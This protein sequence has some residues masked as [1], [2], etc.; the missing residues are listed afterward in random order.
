MGLARS[1]RPAARSLFLTAALA[2]VLG[3]APQPGATPGFDPCELDTSARPQDDLF[4]Y[5]NGGWLD[6]TPLPD[7]R[8]AY[9][10]FLE[11]GDAFEAR[12]R[13]II[14]DAARAPR[15]SRTSQQ[16]VDLYASMLN[17]SRVEELGTKPIKA[18]ID[19][20]A[21]IDTVTAF[22]AET[23]FLSSIAAGGPFAGSASV[24]PEWLQPIVQIFPGGTLLPD[25]D[26][27]VSAAAP[28]AESRA[29]YAAYL[30][31]MLTQVGWP[32]ASDAGPAV[33]ELETAIA[34]AQWAPVDTPD[35]APAKSRFTWSRLASELPGF[36]W[37][38]WAK[39]Q[40]LDR[41]PAL[42][43]VQPAFFKA[44]AA[45]VRSTPLFTW[46][47]WLCAR[48]LTAMAPYLSRRFDRGRF[49]FFGRALTGQSQPRA[50]W[51]RGVG[52]VSRYL[53]D[54]IGRL[55][56][57]KHVPP[58]ARTRVERLT[59]NVQKA[60]R[61]TLKDAAGSSQDARRAASDKIGRL[62]A[63]VGYPA[64]WRDYR[65]LTIDPDDLIGNVQRAQKFENDARMNLLRNPADTDEWMMT[66]QTLNAA[67]SPATNTIVVPAALFQRPVF[68]LDADEA[69][70]YGAIGA[71]IGH[72]IAH[73][74]DRPGMD[75]RDRERLAD[76]RGLV[77]AHRAYRIAL[78]GRPAPVIDGFTGD[79]RFF[80][81]WAQMWRGR[82]RD[83]Y[84]R[85]W[86][87][88][89]PYPPPGERAHTAV[90]NLDAFHEA[91]GVTRA[92]RLY[93][94]PAKRLSF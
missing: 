66:P 41:T 93:L 89:T 8:V 75:E 56:V 61:E 47:S 52:I 50:R 3:V 78:D 34:R 40:G 20:L 11:I 23:G 31:T 77:V 81:G 33:L 58:I 35:G 59:A 85:Q 36:D 43:L 49:D 22:S 68:D 17:E 26:Y 76:L 86:I 9:S 32:N 60:F 83:D 53:G 72:E 5:V 65:G 69:I 4:R 21:A 38:A 74:L 14:E 1:L 42:I 80:I 12:V 37:M 16:I 73:A 84:L 44:F 64:R 10:A 39:P 55:Y 13:A 18:E 45:L 70:N 28:F 92:A 7:D 29:K 94:E 88:T 91:F 62:T 54:S 24:D 79:Q 71:I 82:V 30:T 67:Y 57:E 87:V 90:R 46:K 19:R 6:R 25:R 27:Y 15:R 48:Y 63:K 2:G 51:K